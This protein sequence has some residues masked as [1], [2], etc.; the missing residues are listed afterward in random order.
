MNCILINIS[1]SISLVFIFRKRLCSFFYKIWFLKLN[2]LIYK[3][4]FKEVFFIG[5]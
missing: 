2:V 4:K 5:V 3:D 1:I